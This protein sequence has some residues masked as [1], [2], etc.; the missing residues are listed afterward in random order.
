MDGI[1]NFHITKNIPPSPL[2][3]ITIHLAS[4]PRFNK[5]QE[6]HKH[7]INLCEN[8][9]L[10]CT[11]IIYYWCWKDT[12]RS[13]QQSSKCDVMKLFLRCALRSTSERYCQQTQVLGILERQLISGSWRDK[14]KGQFSTLMQ[15]IIKITRVIACEHLIGSQLVVMVLRAQWSLG[16]IAQFFHFVAEE[17]KRRPK[18]KG[19]VMTRL[20]QVSQ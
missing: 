18:N 17:K 10:A 12:N 4:M 8:Y 2:P 9:T 20:P 14:L 11:S 16:T 5:T 13:A 7:W 1:H 19:I 3:Q 6:G 15:R